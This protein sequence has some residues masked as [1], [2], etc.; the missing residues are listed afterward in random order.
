MLQLD[1]NKSKKLLNYSAKMNFMDTI[2]YTVNWYKNS[3]NK[4]EDM[5]KFSL[6]QITNFYKTKY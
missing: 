2:N 5:F 6:K 3:F 1:T 4:K